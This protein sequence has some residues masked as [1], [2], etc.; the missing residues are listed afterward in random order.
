MATDIVNVGIFIDAD[1]IISNQGKVGTIKNPVQVQNQDSVIYMVS[2]NKNEL[3]GHGAAELNIKVAPNQVI[4]WRTSTLTF[5][6]Q[7]TTNLY[8]FY[9]KSEL[10][11]NVEPSRSSEVIAE[12]NT[13][14]ITNPTPLKAHL[15][16]WRAT[17][18]DTGKVTYHFKFQILEPQQDGTLKTVGCFQWDPFITIGWNN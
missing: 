18:V 13:S 8:E 1:T 11:D 9:P 12:I 5:G 14:D 2:Q 7:Y 4:R 6:G 3:S 10:L 16:Y 17:A 15:G